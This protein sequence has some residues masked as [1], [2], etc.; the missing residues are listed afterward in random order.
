VTPELQKLEPY[1]AIKF[2]LQD[3]QAELRESSLESHEYRLTPLA[4]WIKNHDEIEYLCDLQGRHLAAFKRH[5]SET[6]APNTLQSQ[7]NTVRKFVEFLEAIDAV[8]GGMSDKVRVPSVEQRAKKTRVD[9]E[10]AEAILE[11]LDTYHY[12]S[13]KHALF[14]LLWH[15][16]CR[17]GGVRVLDLRDLV[18]DDPERAH[19]KFRHR[20]DSGTPLKNGD[21]GE[22]NAGLKE[23]CADVLADYVDE[24]RQSS[25]DDH[26]RAPLFTTRQGRIS[27]G[28]IRREI[29]A[30]T[31]PCMV[32]ECPHDRDPETCE[33]ITGPPS[34]CPSKRP[35]HD[36][37]RGAVSDHLARGWPI[38]D[39]AE[40]VNA[41]P[42][43]LRAHYD[44]RTEREAMLSRSPL[45]EAEDDGPK[46]DD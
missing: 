37:R 22:R 12:A 44:V 9:R 5:R 6:I 3:R 21:D 43:V 23:W 13:R 34:R 7:M 17:I 39:V 46:S 8:R 1:D 14:A 2:Y 30:L 31:Q 4:E 27:E 38:D 15:T 24:R 20:P 32:G 10:R 41:T 35:P 18:L 36:V 26:G 28:W 11:Y 42:R 33:A 40:R 45:L 25:T 16:G 29:Y 19:V